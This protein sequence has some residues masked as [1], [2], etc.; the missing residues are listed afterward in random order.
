MGGLWRRPAAGSAGRHRALRRLGRAED[1]VNAVMFLA[2]DLS[3]F[4][5]GQHLPVDGGK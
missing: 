5:T 2:S 4:I 1:V 3:S